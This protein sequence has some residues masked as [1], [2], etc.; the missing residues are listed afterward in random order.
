MAH[1]FPPVD[2]IFDDLDKFRDFCRFNGKRF[3]EADLYKD[4][5]PVWEDYKRFLRG[6]YRKPKYSSNKKTFNRKD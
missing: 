1:S 5:A 3:N 6:D 4:G 2:Q